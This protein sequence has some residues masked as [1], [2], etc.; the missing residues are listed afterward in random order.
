MIIKNIFENTIALIYAEMY[1]VKLR[2]LEKQ[3]KKYI[4]RK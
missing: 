3:S 4:Q 1:S 2:N